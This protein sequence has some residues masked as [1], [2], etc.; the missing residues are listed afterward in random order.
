MSRSLIDAVTTVD[1][2]TKTKRVKLTYDHGQYLR[3]DK[4]AKWVKL[5]MEIAEL[6][7]L[8]P[9][10]KQRVDVR[11]KNDFGGTSLLFYVLL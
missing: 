4:F 1:R 5:N 3:T 9:D 6:E 8:F 10:K 7:R 2:E 11:R